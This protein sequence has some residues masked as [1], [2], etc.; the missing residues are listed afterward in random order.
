MKALDRIESAYLDAYEQQS[1][2]G[3]L[4][5]LDSDF[6]NLK[7]EQ[8]VGILRLEKDKIEMP[9]ALHHLSNIVNRLDSFKVEAILADCN[10]ALFTIDES[11]KFK[12]T[13]FK[14]NKLL[15]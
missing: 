3:L 15:G 10:D 11:A 12:S 6:D 4:R 5:L 7:K 1:M 2:D 13:I 14:F 9:K 8:M